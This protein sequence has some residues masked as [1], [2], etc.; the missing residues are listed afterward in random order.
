MPGVAPAH[1]RNLTRDVAKGIPQ[2]A[3][4]RQQQGA[5]GRQLHAVGAAAKESDLQ[6]VLEALEALAQGRLAQP[7]LLSRAS[8]VSLFSDNDEIFEVPQLH[9][10]TAIHDLMN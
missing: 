2:L 3:R 1:I 7:Q 4:A 9:D 5:F 6:R 10:I 8:K